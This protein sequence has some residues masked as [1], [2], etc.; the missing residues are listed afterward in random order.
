MADLIARGRLEGESETEVERRGKRELETGKPES[1]IRSEPVP[2]GAVRRPER[3]RHKKDT[4]CLVS[5]ETLY[6][7]QGSRKTHLDNCT[8]RE[9]A[10]SERSNTEESETAFR[11]GSTNLLEGD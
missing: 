11:K 5:L 9:N 6:R 10:K 1:R 3:D 7:L 4:D 2:E 8:E